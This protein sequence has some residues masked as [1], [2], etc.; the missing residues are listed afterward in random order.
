MLRED[1]NVFERDKINWESWVE[2][3]LW[4]NIVYRKNEY[5]GFDILIKPEEY[6]KDHY[7]VHIQL[8]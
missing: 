1:C 5:S 4:T 2:S 3:L 7:S 6:M 8:E